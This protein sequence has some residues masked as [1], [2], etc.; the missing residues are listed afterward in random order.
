MPL[1]LNGGLGGVF[2]PPPATPQKKKKIFFWVFWKKNEVLEKKSQM[3]KKESKTL[4]FLF[5]PSFG[6]KK[7]G[8]WGKW[9]QKKKKVASL[10][11]SPQKLGGP[12]E[13][14]PNFLLKMGE[15]IFF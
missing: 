8:F 1:S 9:A 3:G 11:P 15:I 14:L 5:L 7:L 4:E 12:P 13:I 6:K 2:S 10:A